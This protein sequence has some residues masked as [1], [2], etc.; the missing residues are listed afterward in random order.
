MHQ[1]TVSI[2][3]IALLFLMIGTSVALGQAPPGPVVRHLFRTAG[4]PQPTRFNPAQGI[5]NFEPGA[6]T[7]FH[8]HPGQVLVTVLEGENTFSG[9]WF[10]WRR[11]GRA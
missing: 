5:L 2:A 11:Q 3:L 1:R 10:V 6:A 7:P 4:L 8:R 9:G